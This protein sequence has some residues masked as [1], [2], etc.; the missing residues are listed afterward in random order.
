MRVLLSSPLLL[1]SAHSNTG[2]SRSRAPPQ[3][4]VLGSD[5]SFWSR[6]PV[7]SDKPVPD[8]PQAKYRRL[9][10]SPPRARQ[11]TARSG[12]ESEILPQLE[13]GT[14]LMMGDNPEL[15]T[16]PARRR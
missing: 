16:M 10:L 12:T 9:I 2:V 6:D 4:S 3:R 11:S 7:P 13:P 8:T 5:W 15:P 14:V 1:R